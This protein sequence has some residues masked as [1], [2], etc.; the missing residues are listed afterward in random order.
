[1]NDARK[2]RK[3]DRRRRD[4]L[5]CIAA[6]IVGVACYIVVETLWPTEYVHFVETA[7]LESLP[8]VRLLDP[9]DGA[10]ELVRTEPNR[11]TV[12]WPDTEVR[13]EGPCRVPLCDDRSVKVL[14]ALANGNTYKV[15]LDTG[16]AGR[17]ALTDTIVLENGLAVYPMDGLGPNVGGLCDIGELRI[18]GMTILNPPC[19]YWLAHYERRVLGWTVWREREMN[20]GLGLLKGFAYLL[21]DRARDE[22]EFG[23]PDAFLPREPGRWRRY[24]MSL[25]PPSG[26]RGTRAMV[27]LPL[28]GR[29]GPITFDT[30]STAGLVVSESVWAE[31]SE[32]L[33]PIGQ[34]DAHMRT[35][36]HGDV[37]CRILTVAE[38]DVADMRLANAR[39]NV[40][41]DDTYL[42]P[43]ECTLGMAYFAETAIV[44]DFENGLF[45]IRG[46][47]ASGDQ[48]IT[49]PNQ[50]KS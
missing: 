28:V 30:G 31:L 13:L 20:L 32:T 8:G 50:A 43:A 33:R 3:R 16:Y 23:G 42:G 22:V 27:G 24:P 5:L 34:Q 9:N 19:I 4:R 1:M 7:A 44:L 40:T 36:L 47:P 14:G 46:E 26:A 12:H 21:I 17:L 15:L 49:D 41:D 18:G 45:W 6:A 48:E 39:I 11:V 29:R 10:F 35:P 37:P 2:E 38:M 25:D